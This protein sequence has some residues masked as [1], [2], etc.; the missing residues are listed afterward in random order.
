[1]ASLE[2]S[3]SPSPPSSEWLIGVVSTT[4]QLQILLLLHL[5]AILLSDA[6]VP[7]LMV[8]AISGRGLDK[9]S[10]KSDTGRSNNST[11]SISSQVVSTLLICWSAQNATDGT[12]SFILS[13]ILLAIN[14]RSVMFVSMMMA[15][16]FASML[17]RP[18]LEVENALI[19]NSFVII[20]LS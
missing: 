15:N 5:D 9:N 19:F 2:D 8:T 13:D 12:A 20:N 1:M 6:S 17:V 4:P 11:T 7:A 10:N 18:S 14:D 3:S 16:R